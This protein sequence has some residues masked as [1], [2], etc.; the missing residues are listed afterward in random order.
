VALQRRKLTPGGEIPKDFEFVSEQGPAQFA[1]LF[2][3]KTTLIVY[4]MMF[5]PER[6]APCPMCTS[7]LTSWNGTAVTLRERVAIAV[8]A[9]SPIERIVEATA[10]ANGEPPSWFRFQTGLTRKQRAG[11]IE[12]RSEGRFA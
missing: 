5:G 6:K 8:T 3:D 4:S 2:G 11:R 10:L 12:S 1:S 7:F 9:R